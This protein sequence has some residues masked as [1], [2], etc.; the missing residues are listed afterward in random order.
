MGT[1]TRWCIWV[2]PLSWQPAR[3]PDLF[4]RHKHSPIAPRASPF[5]ARKKQTAIGRFGGDDRGGFPPSVRGRVLFIDKD[6]L[7]TDGIFAGKHTYRDDIT[8]EE[9][10]AVTFENFDPNFNTLLSSGDV[11]VG[12]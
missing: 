6:N 10:A 12:D 1:L 8:P 4:A 9:M 11:V 3:L 2:H 7:N 5:G